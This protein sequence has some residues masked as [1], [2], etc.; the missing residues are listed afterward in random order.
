MMV[1]VPSGSV[2]R[3][4]R[5]ASCARLSVNSRNSPLSASAGGVNS[6]LVSEMLDRPSTPCCELSAVGHRGGLW[7]H[8]VR[9]RGGLIVGSVQPLATVA[10]A[11]LA[12]RLK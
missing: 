3:R 11:A 10:T 12:H 9:Q 5:M 1:T 6:G 2:R 8:Y 7:S 4:S